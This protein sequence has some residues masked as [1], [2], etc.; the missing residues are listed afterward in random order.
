MKAWG[1]MGVFL[2]LSYIVQLTG[3]LETPFSLPRYLSLFFYWRPL[4][5]VINEELSLQTMA[6]YVGVA[7]VA[8]VAAVLAFRR[9]DLPL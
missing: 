5:V 1:L 2:F 7:V 6:V 3:S 4:E 8:L 9:R